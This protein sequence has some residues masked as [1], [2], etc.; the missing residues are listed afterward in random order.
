MACHSHPS[1]LAC[2]VGHYQ[3]E[4]PVTTDRPWLTGCSGCLLP[5]TLNDQGG[6]IREAPSPTLTAASCSNLEAILPW[7]G[8]D[9]DKSCAVWVSTG[10][11]HV[12]WVSELL[13]TLTILTSV[14]PLAIIFRVHGCKIWLGS[15]E[16]KE[17]GGC[18]TRKA[19]PTDQRAAQVVSHGWEPMSVPDCRLQPAN[20]TCP[21]HPPM[22]SVST[23]DWTQV[24]R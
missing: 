15:S 16:G 18:C 5:P 12:A 20:F 19:L 23:T 24:H 13:V 22:L 7:F 2:D 21:L 11:D 9:W 17:P 10:E 4:N 6:T 3:T 1:R 8:L 14:V